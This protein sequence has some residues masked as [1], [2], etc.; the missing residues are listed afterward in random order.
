M[1]AI[2][3]GPSRRDDLLTYYIC[4]KEYNIQKVLLAGGIIRNCGS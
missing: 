2:H 3:H 1:L 4:L